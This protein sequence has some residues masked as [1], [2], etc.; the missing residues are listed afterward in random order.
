M[1]TNT[2]EALKFGTKKSAITNTSDSVYSN[3]TTAAE[4]TL[5]IYYIIIYVFLVYETALFAYRFIM[6]DFTLRIRSIQF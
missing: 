5:F 6:N 3:S 2:F 4:L 1:T